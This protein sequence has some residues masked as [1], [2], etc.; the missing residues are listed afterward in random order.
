MYPEGVPVL[1]FNELQLI[2]HCFFFERRYP[3]DSIMRIYTDLYICYA[4]VNKYSPYWLKVEK[5]RVLVGLYGTGK[6]PRRMHVR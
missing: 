5:F 6:I 2:L 3:I 1:D 4:V